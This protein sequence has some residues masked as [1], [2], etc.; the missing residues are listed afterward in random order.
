M[1]LQLLRRKLEF[2]HE[3]KVERGIDVSGSRP[4]DK[5]FERRYTHGR[6]NARSFPDRAGARSI[7]EVQG[8]E[9]YVLGL[10]AEV[11]GCLTGDI[12]V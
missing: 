9:I 11:P 7:A 2:P 6:I 8:D 3:I 1:F 5:T 4:H 10:A 12:E